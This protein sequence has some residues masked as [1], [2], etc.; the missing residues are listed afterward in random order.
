MAPQT[1]K[2]VPK[3][4]V[5]EATLA[6]NLQCRHCGSR[7]GRPRP[8]E[9]TAE[10]A[11]QVF[12]DLAALGCERVT[13]SGGEP[14]MRGDWL[15]L[16]SSASEA[17]LRVGII[18]NALKFDFEAACEAKKRGLG[19]VGLSVDGPSAK[20]HDMIRGKVGHFERLKRAMADCRRAE[21]PFAVVTF[22][23]QNNI[24]ALEEM[25]EMIRDQGAFAWQVQMG[26]EMG[27]MKDNRDLLVSP[28]QL[29]RLQSTL[30]RLIKRGELRIDISDSIGYHGHHEH[31]LRAHP[32]Q[33]RKPGRFTGCPAGMRVVGIE[34]NGNVKGCLS[35]MAGYN[36]EGQSF[37]E[38]NVRERS[39][40]DIWNDPNAFAYNR[41]WQL[42]DLGGFCRTCK[43]ATLCRGGCRAKM[44]AS[45][46]GVE[47]PLCAYRVE[48]ETAM[49]KRAGQAAAAVLVA[50]MLGAGAGGCD[51]VDEK[52]RGDTA[53]QTDTD[54]ATGTDTE[55]VDSDTYESTD[56]GMPE[57]GFPDT[58]P[59][60][61][62]GMPNTDVQP[63][64]GIPD[65]DETAPDYS[66][67]DPGSDVTDYG[68]PSS[69][70]ETLDTAVLEY[71]IPDTEPQPEYGMS[72]PDDTDGKR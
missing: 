32:Q 68:I 22:V 69:D 34:S 48:C 67:P 4:C 47:N 14:T 65:T 56:Y 53:S 1:Q 27:N 6:C 31:I 21:V 64:Y 5:F 24:E 70:S 37:V 12:R 49:P 51:E 29:L 72:Q 52:E 17:G 60:P 18:T 7:A 54:T 19:A 55:T 59:Q 9:L 44:T 57:Y 3:T 66:A 58:E 35:I 39:L 13:I 10:E 71:G 45:G 33:G 23:H 11:S 63:D 62:Y 41:Q 30:A 50:S 20:I 38:G 36:E 43:N 42:D 8:D 2:Y 46:G 25:Y 15:E 61:A 26:T 16:V 28:K 40:V